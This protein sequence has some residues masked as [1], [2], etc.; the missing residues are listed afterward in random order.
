MHY[1]QG[2]TSILKHQ[3]AGKGSLYSSLKFSF[4]IYMTLL[5]SIVIFQFCFWEIVNH[6]VFLD[7]PAMSYAP[8]VA[9]G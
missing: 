5:L 3:T 8:T 6:N 1:K 4:K 9:T 2:P 7:T